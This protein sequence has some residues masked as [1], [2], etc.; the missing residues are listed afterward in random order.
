MLRLSL[1]L[2]T[3]VR[4]AAIAVLVALLLPGVG[5]DPATAAQA[6][7]H[8][9][10]VDKLDRHLRQALDREGDWPARRVIVRVDPTAIGS[11]QALMKARGDELIRFHRGIS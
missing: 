10:K 7:G 9:R 3:G 2:S 4:R 6:A 1:P 11:V 5:S 8:K